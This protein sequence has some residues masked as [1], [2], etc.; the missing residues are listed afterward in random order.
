MQSQAFAFLFECFS[1]SSINKPFA[2]G[3][4]PEKKKRGPY[5]P[6][7][8]SKSLIIK[9]SKMQSRSYEGRP[10]IY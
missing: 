6:T 5:H 4:M 1:V 10:Y 2:Q 3:S 9:K 7:Q 8:K